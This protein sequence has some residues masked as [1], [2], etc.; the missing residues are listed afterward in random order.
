MTVKPQ[1]IIGLS[2]AETDRNEVSGKKKI[3]NALVDPRKQSLRRIKTLK[4][5]PRIQRP[6]REFKPLRL[7][8]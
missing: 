7:P 4:E 5:L 8:N 1:K 2:A 3:L 6:D